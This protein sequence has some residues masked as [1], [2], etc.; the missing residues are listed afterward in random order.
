MLVKQ[1]DQNMLLASEETMGAQ[2]NKEIKTD[3]QVFV[4]HD[5]YDSEKSLNF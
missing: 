1:C 3:L 2:G 4:T 5:N